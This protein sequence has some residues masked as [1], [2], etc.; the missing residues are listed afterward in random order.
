MTRS[1][2]S[3]GG[4]PFQIGL[5]WSLMLNLEQKHQNWI[6]KEKCLRFDTNNI[7]D[8]PTPS[9]TLMSGLDFVERLGVLLAFFLRLVNNFVRLKQQSFLVNLNGFSCPD[10]LHHA[11][12]GLHCFRL[13]IQFLLRRL[14]LRLW[15]YL[16][17]RNLIRFWSNL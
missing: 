2:K 4:K 7:L 5:V 15:V 1:N 9:W 13:L 16:F 8:E 6:I 12:A 11:F 3:H 17:W 14:I 10:V